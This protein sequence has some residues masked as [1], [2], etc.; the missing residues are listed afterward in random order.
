VGNKKGAWLSP[1][2]VA[3]AAMPS[4]FGNQNYS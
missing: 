1:W 3:K 2:P 4:V